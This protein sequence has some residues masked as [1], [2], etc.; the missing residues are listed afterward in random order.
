MERPTCK[1]CRAPI[2]WVVAES[3]RRLPLDPAPHPAG[4]LVRTGPET[5][6]V[7]AK[8]EAFAGPRYRTHYAGCPGAAR[9]RRKR[10]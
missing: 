10:A 1:A 7:L 4:T 6:R 9:F 2:V 5:V 3:G 8:D